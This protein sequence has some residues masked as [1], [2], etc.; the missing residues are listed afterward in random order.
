M[1]LNSSEHIV[2]LMV[3]ESRV[4]VCL[5]MLVMVIFSNNAVDLANHLVNAL[6]LFAS[7]DDKLPVHSSLYCVVSNGIHKMLS[8]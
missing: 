3:I 2:P 6:L 7:L 4:M 5:P 1:L 8:L